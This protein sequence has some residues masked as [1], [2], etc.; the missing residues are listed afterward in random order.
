MSADVQVAVDVMGWYATSASTVTPGSLYLAAAPERWL[1]SRVDGDRTRLAPGDFLELPIEFDETGGRRLTA[2][3]F[4]LT[5]TGGFGNGWF[6]AWNGAGDPPGTSALNFSVG[7]TS[8]NLVTVPV[9]RVG[10]GSRPGSGLYLAVVEN[11][12]RSSAHLIVDAAGSYFTDPANYGS[13]HVVVPATRIGDSRT[14][15]GTAKGTVAGGRTVNVSVPTG[16]VTDR[17]DAFEGVLTMA[18]PTAATYLTMFASGEDRPATSSVNSTAARNRSNG[19]STYPGCLDAACRPG[20]AV[21]NSA[22]AVNVILDVTGRFDLTDETIGAVGA[23]PA[24][25]APNAAPKAVAD[26]TPKLA[27]TP[28]VRR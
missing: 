20:Y 16:L 8:P 27:A 9:R 22:G 13:T 1:D 23:P 21:Y 4:N 12:S 28:T 2:M 17:A 24:K 10:A 11:T 19:F 26:R 18:N 25:R 5:A 15:L 6:T 3:Q 14:G 7:E